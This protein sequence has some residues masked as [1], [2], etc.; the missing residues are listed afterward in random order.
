MDRVTFS[1]ILSKNLKNF[2]ICI[3]VIE[4]NAYPYSLFKVNPY[5]KSL[6]NY[7]TLFFLI[8]EK[9]NVSLLKVL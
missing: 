2:R 3:K 4:V 9:D 8:I 5:S 7:E 1:Y 6:K